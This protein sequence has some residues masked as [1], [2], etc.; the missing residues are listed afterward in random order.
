MSGT[1]RQQKYGKLIQ[2]DLSGI[3]QKEMKHLFNNDF[4]TVTEVQMSP[5]L[6]IAKAYISMILTKD[7]LA[8]M[9]KI[10][11]HKSEIRKVLGIK[12]AKQVRHIPELIF[13]LDETLDN[14]ERINR[15]LDGL[16]IP[17]DSEE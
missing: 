4:I 15:V 5:D 11:E 14:A 16:E 7:R 13:Y 6:S 10:N 9:E 8:L 3:F 1:I 17:P 12:I 2:K